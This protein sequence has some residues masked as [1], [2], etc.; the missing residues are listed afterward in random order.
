MSKMD[1]ILYNG[2]EFEVE[3]GLTA[4]D[5]KASMTQVYASVANAHIEQRKNDSGTTTWVVTE[6]GGDKGLELDL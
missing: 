2:E 3:S 6:R 4:Q 5:V 1:T